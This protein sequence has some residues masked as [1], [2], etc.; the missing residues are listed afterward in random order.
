MAVKDLG[1]FDL[2]NSEE[3][4]IYLRVNINTVNWLLSV[5]NNIADNPE[6]DA[7]FWI[8]IGCSTYQP[9]AALNG[10]AEGIGEN[11]HKH[12]PRPFE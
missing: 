5:L 2:T 7:Y 8:G 12:N 11:T 3:G 6:R 4:G 1:V 9:N 10:A